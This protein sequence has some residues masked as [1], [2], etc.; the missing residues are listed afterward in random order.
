MNFPENNYFETARHQIEQR[1]RM[2][3]DQLQREQYLTSMRYNSK[4]QY[5]AAPESSQSQVRAVSGVE[6]VRTAPVDPFNVL[7]FMD[8][9]HG[10]I[11]TKQLG[12]DG[13]SI[14]KTYTLSKDTAAQ[15]DQNKNEFCGEQ[16]C[17]WCTPETVSAT[18]Q[19]L[20][21]NRESFTCRRTM[22]DSRELVFDTYL[23]ALFN[24]Q[25]N[26]DIL[27]EAKLRR[28]QAEL[29][30]LEQSRL[31]NEIITLLKEK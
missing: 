19:Y 12:N 15:G 13:V 8:N 3:L 2:E 31:L 29:H 14:I 4:P 11:Y 18:T 21:W 6:D 17:V 27:S 7:F 9:E 22:N 23:A 1:Y 25:V 30:N 5:Q 20:K 16:D 26:I 10:I 28:E 24:L